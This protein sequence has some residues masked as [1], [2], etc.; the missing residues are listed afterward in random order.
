MHLGHFFP[1]QIFFRGLGLILYRK[2]TT[3]NPTQPNSPQTPYYL[4]YNMTG[5][6]VHVRTMISISN[7]IV[8]PVRFVLYTALHIR[9]Q[10]IPRRTT[11]ACIMCKMYFFAYCWQPFLFRPRVFPRAL[12]FGVRRGPECILRHKFAPRTGSVAHVLG[13]ESRASWVIFTGLR[14]ATPSRQGP[15][16]PHN[17]SFSVCCCCYHTVLQLSSSLRCGSHD[18]IAIAHQALPFVTATDGASV[19]AYVMFPVVLPNRYEDIIPRAG[20]LLACG[21]RRRT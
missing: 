10:P 11:Y 6:K 16:K 12:G 14:S 4:V 3:R 21:L 19:C 15:W 9:L 2:Q 13:V 7:V 1:R 18:T 20:Q 8:F 5:N 17:F